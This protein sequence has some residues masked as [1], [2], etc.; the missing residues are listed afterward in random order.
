MELT[1]MPNLAAPSLR[2]AGPNASSQYTTGFD[3]IA[4]AGPND[5][6]PVVTL[7]A[8]ARPSAWLLGPGLA[9]VLG[10]LN[11]YY[12]AGKAAAVLAAAGVATV[13][14]AG[15]AGAAPG[16]PYIV[17][18]SDLVMWQVLAADAAAQIAA[19]V[20]VLAAGGNVNKGGNP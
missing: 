11:T 1:L 3:V 17:I 9:A 15:T 10:Q 14:Q 18:N 2:P 4:S 8:Y 7:Q 19:M 6:L 16:T 20:A 13:A 12:G 5:G